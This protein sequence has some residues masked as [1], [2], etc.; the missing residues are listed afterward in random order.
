[1]TAT[2]CQIP[3]TIYKG[4][5]YDTRWCFGQTMNIHTTWLVD[6]LCLTLIAITE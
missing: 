5:A 4:G 2:M 1:M 6:P 3:L